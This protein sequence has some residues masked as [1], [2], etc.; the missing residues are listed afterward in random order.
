MLH[1]VPTGYTSED[2]DS[3]LPKHIDRNW[4]LFPQSSDKHDKHIK[5]L[6]FQVSIYL[7]VGRAHLMT[8]SNGHLYAY[9]SCTISLMMVQAIHRK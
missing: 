5:C 3:E 6:I 1:L 2:S 4:M 8:H 7:F 9:L